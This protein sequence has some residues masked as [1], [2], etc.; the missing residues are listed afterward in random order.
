MKGVCEHHDGGPVGAAFPDKLL[1]WR[2]QFLK[3][4]GCN[5]IRTAHNPRT[6]EFYKLCDQLG[7]LVM[8]EIFDG[9][10]KKAAQDYGA[11][12]FK[13]HWKKDVKS[14]VRRD[15]NHPSVVIYS[16]GNETGHSDKNDI[17][18]FIHEFDHC[19]NS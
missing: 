8:D 14:W 15:R 12:F 9:W 17:T 5:A 13:E 1:K 3:D 10:H 11:R 7:M 2:I 19:K 6:P 18:E 16:I 4:M